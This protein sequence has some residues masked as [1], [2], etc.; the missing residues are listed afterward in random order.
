MRKI[1]SLL[2][3][4]LLLIVLI[5]MAALAQTSVTGKVTDAQNAPLAGATISVR[6]SNISTQTDQNGNFTISVPNSNA[7][8][9]VSFVGYTSRTLDAS[10]NMSIQLEEDRT[11]LS[12]VVV[13]GLATSVKRSNLANSVATISAKELTGSTRQQTV[14]AALQGKV[15][16]AQ[17][18]A[19]SG[20]PG[21]GFSVRLRGISSINLSS[22]PLYIIDGVYMNNSQFQ[23]GGGTGPFSGATTTGTSSTQDQTPNRLAD[24]NPADIENIEILKGPSAAAI[25]GTRANA[26]VVIITTKRGRA[27]KTNIS[28]GQDV[29]ISNAINLLGLHE[30]KW[31]Q[32]FKVGTDKANAATY[33][34]LKA[35]RNPGDETWNYEDIIYGNTW[36]LLEILV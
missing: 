1:A 31:D 36:F 8:L 30:S 7:R 6:G 17:I 27:G 9:V 10:S 16:G 18:L 12:E 26:G 19:T 20:A 3:M 13:T 22:E 28:F 14:D 4:L 29:G 15:A 34:N 2:T 5:P 23:S 21:G 32:Q 11:N 33:T 24:L 25:Y 35:A